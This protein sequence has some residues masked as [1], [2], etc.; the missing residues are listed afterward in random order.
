MSAS[1]SAAA[2]ASL[3]PLRVRAAR[4]PDEA[5][6]LGAADHRAFREGGPEM[7]AA[8]YR[9]NTYLRHAS[10][11]LVAERDG[12]LAG[13]CALLRFDLALAGVDVPAMGNAPVGVAPESRRQGV[14]DKLM[15]DALRRIRRAG[16]PLALLYPFSVSFY[17][18]FGYELCEWVDL[19]RVAPAQLPASPL[20]R[21]VRRLDPGADAA[22][23]RALYDRCRSTGATG[24]FVRDDYWWK[25]R[26]FRRA[27]EWFVF[28]DPRTRRVDGLL[29]YGVP[30]APGYPYQ[31]ASVHDFWAATPAA[32]AG[33]VGALAAFAE[34]FA[35]IEIY[36]PR[37]QGL[38]LLVEHGRND[39]EM[40]T[41]AHLGAYTATCAMARLVDVAA[42]FAAHPG[43]RRVRGKLGLDLSDPVFPDQDGSF[44]VSFGASGA[45]V[46]PGETAR[47][48]LAISIQRLSQ[49]YF[50]AAPATQLMAQGLVHGAAS[51]A[52][53][54]DAAFAG[55]PL[56]LGAANYF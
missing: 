21:H 55:A 43:A 29:G 13:Q 38:P 27:D 22:S 8:Y 11:V 51:A 3:A 41:R 1:V 47:A 6:A 12:V 31:I 42:A 5:A 32:Y 50:A 20:R 46:V 18:R 44:D 54:L 52:A 9:D 28:V 49:V 33:L 4:L 35:R 34:Q 24:P 53:L 23:V 10:G 26:V 17:R 14:A 7:W 30:A 15:R 39:V 19:L 40:E 48:R 36:L 25:E 2:S 37:G 45:R 56:H 16:V